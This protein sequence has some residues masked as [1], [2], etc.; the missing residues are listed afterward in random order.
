MSSDESCSLTLL[1]EFV[2]AYKLD[3]RSVNCKSRRCRRKRYNAARGSPAA[4]HGAR[5]GASLLVPRLPSLRHAPSAACDRRAVATHASLDCG[6]GTGANLELLGRFGR[7]F[8]FDLTA[9]GLRIGREAGRTRLARATVTAAPFPERGVRPRHVVRR[10]VL[11]RGRRTSGR[12]SPKCTG[13][14]G[15]AVSP[16]STSRRWSPA[17]RPLGAE[18]RGAPVQPRRARA[19]CLDGAGFAIVRLTYTNATLF[20]PMLA[21]PGRSSGG[22]GCAEERGAAG[23]HGAAGA[24]QRAADGRAAARRACWLRWFDSPFGSSLLCLAQETGVGTRHSKIRRPDA[25]GPATPPQRR[26]SAGT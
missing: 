19:G 3:L 20:L 16:W 8:G 12:R 6:C 5:R 9:V 11:A 17:R 24:D 25:A 18:P 21:G 1:E 7:A 23:D 22:A 15:P 14:S 26:C 13:C 10:P 4:R 2:A